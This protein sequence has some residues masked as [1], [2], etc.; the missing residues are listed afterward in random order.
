[1]WR[2]KL[3][4]GKEQRGE[5][6]AGSQWAKIGHGGEEHEKKITIGETKVCHMGGYGVSVQQ[7]KN[8]FK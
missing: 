1:L 8:G 7:T 5:A 6:R 2:W 3:R 4:E